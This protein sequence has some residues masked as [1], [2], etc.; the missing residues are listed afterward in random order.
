MRAGASEVL[1]AVNGGFDDGWNST[2]PPLAVRWAA[3]GVGSL[4]AGLKITCSVH[5]GQPICVQHCVMHA[6]CIVA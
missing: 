5:A 4:P 3:T 2:H 1:A 6:D